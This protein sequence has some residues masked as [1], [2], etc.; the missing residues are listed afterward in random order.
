MPFNPFSILTSKIFA[1]VSAVLLIALGVCWIG[2]T[3]AADQ[4]NTARAQ[5]AV[6]EGKLAVSNASIAALR[7]TVDQQ[8]QVEQQRAS[9]YNAAAKLADQQR[10]HLTQ[11]AKSSDAKIAR[12]KALGQQPGDCAVK[13]ETK[14]LAEGL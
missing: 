7:N 4:R 3:H 9:E 5:I 2:W 14:T 10:I 6:E 1:G 8:N 12:L 13:S 11:Q